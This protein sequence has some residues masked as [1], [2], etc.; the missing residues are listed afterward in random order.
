MCTFGNKK[1]RPLL[2]VP[3]SLLFPCFCLKICEPF[4]PLQH[5]KTPKTPNLFKSCPSDCFWGF[6]LGGLKFVKICPKNPVFQIFPNFTPPDWNPQKQSLGKILDKFGV[7][8]VF[9]CCKGKK[10]SQLKMV[11]KCCLCLSRRQNA[12]RKRGLRHLEI[13]IYTHIKRERER[14]RERERARA[15]ERERERETDVASD[16]VPK[17]SERLKGGTEIDLQTQTFHSSFFPKQ[18]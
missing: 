18:S 11:K 10:G 7:S 6:Q 15:R 9:E 5:S 14:E 13:Y 16:R 4:F 1:A 8:G 17:P 3:F 12:G 2:V